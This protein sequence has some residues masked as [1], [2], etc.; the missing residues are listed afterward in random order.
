MAHVGSGRLAAD[1]SVPS[2]PASSKGTA[3]S[4][5]HRGS[6]FQCKT[7]NQICNISSSSSR[8][9]SSSSTGKDDSGGESLGRAGFVE[10]GAREECRCV[11]KDA[12]LASGLTVSCPTLDAAPREQPF[13]C[14]SSADRIELFDLV[15]FLFTAAGAPS[16]SSSVYKASRKGPAMYSLG[17]ST[18]AR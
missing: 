3:P 11:T 9:S 2:L 10:A 16:R 12:N 18:Q 13:S 14:L 15:L 8:N 7:S 6:N 4:A 17:V 1:L 5:M